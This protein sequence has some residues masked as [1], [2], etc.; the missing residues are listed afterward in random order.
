MREITIPYYH[1]EDL[2]KTLLEPTYPKTR[3]L[4]YNNKNYVS[5]RSFH[6][7]YVFSLYPILKARA[8]HLTES[9]IYLHL[10]LLQIRQMQDPFTA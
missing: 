3:N 6:E 4:V 2:K 7:C 10:L 8:N 9:Q 5:G 1:K